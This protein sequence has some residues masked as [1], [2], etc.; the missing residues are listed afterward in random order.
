MNKKII[1]IFFLLIVL[2]S[3]LV[4]YIYIKQTSTEEKKF[5]STIETVDDKI[6][7]DEVNNVFI[8]ETD[9]IEIGEMI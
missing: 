6:I 3:V 5:N 2:A 4:A 8:N 7:S 9:E 1:S